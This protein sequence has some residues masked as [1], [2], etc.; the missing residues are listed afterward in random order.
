MIE[1]GFAVDELRAIVAD[2]AEAAA[3]AGVAI[4]T[5]DTKVV[6]RG[7]ADGIYITTA[8]RRRDPRRI[9]RSAPSW[10]SRATGCS[11][12]ARSATTAWR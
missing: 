8:G 6:G 4:V 2:M 5:G 11:C 9:A 12:R 3:A 1:E 10:S 7:A